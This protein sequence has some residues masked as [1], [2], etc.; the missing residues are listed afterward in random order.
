MQ[1]KKATINKSSEKSSYWESHLKNW[2]KS[3]I[4]QSEYCRS[5]NLNY[6]V[7]HYWKR[8]LSR[9]RI[10]GKSAKL[11]QIDR[12]LLSANNLKERHSTIDLSSGGEGR[13]SLRMWVGAGSN[14]C[15]EVEEGFSVDV[16]TRLLHCLGRV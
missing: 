14:Y 8:K 12:T 4:N 15:L 7:F 11:V 13:P 16:L 2:E 10:I 6:S 9:S 1:K 3:G 5:N